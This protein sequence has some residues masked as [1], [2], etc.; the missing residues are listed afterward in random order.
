MNQLNYWMTTLR[1]KFRTYWP[2]V[3]GLQTGLL[4]S[5]GLGGY[6]SARCPI[7][8]WTTLAGLLISLVASISGSTFLNMWWDRDIDSRMC[9]TKNRPLATGETKPWE[10][11][12]VGSALSALGVGL[13]TLMNPLFG[14]I[15]FAGVFFDVV[16]YTI[17]LKRR[18][19]WSIVLGGL[20]GG[21]PILA[22]RALGLGVID[23]VG[24]LLCLAILFWIPTHIMTFN[25]KYQAD[26][27]TAG[28]PTFPSTYGFPVT[29]ALVAFS[30]VLAALSI[31]IAA[32]GVGM[33][34]GYLRV[35]IVLSTGLLALAGSSLLRPSE[36]INFGLFKYASLYMLSSMLL[37]VIFGILDVP[38]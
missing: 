30:S 17:W 14:L 25:M 2:L 24:I 9:R 7:H 34:W 33:T 28:V 31:G 1:T 4:V 29:R 26:Y 18:T 6:M 38:A 20:A 16:V 13:A 15:I 11:F 36:S 3:K 27:K 35:L 37:M 22:G 5:T 10:A 12:W 23:W 19:S 21:M 32:S 8:D